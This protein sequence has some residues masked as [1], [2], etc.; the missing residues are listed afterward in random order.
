MKERLHLP[1]E[2]DGRLW[3]HQYRGRDYRAHRH[4]ELEFNLV[5]RG[6]ASYIVDGKR[7][8]LSPHTLIWLFPG[9]DHVLIEQSKDYEMTLGVIR[10][11]ALRRLC[12]TSRYQAMRKQHPEGRF[13]SCLSTEAAGRLQSLMQPGI[14]AEL[15]GD[16]DRLN[17]ALPV[18]FVE[19]WRAHVEAV[20]SPPA[21]AIHSAVERAIQLIRQNHPC[22][23]DV[24]QLAQASGL[25]PSQL[26]RL[27]HRQ[28]GMSLVRYRQRQRLEQCLRLYDQGRHRTMLDAALDAGFGSYAQFHRVFRQMMGV[29]PAAYR[30]A[31]RQS[32]GR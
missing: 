14:D 17:A 9:Q 30:R 26:S 23:N 6:A 25:S 13:C 11:R 7:Y 32:A 31:L 27:F 12:R 2:Q 29:G 1:P 10:P 24:A 21:A 19:T 20:E 22:Q 4:D 16:A 18:V 5:T 3:R 8:D 15:D 28:I